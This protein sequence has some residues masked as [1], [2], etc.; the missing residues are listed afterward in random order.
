MVIRVQIAVGGTQREIVIDPDELP[1]GLNEDI[2]NAR[3]SGKWRDLNKAFADMIGV[4]HEEFRQIKQGDFK[5]I[6]QAIQ[7]AQKE[8]T[9]IPN[10]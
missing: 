3:E 6:M 8:A 10:P 4:T 7:D 5:R 9:D 2:E 1:M